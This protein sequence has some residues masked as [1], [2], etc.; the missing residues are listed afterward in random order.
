MPLLP[1][2][3]GKFPSVACL[4]NCFMMATVCAPA[5]DSTSP[6]IAI[7]VEKAVRSNLPIELSD[8][9]QAL[10]NATSHDAQR[11]KAIED[12]L[13]ECLKNYGK[14]LKLTAELIHGGEIPALPESAQAILERD[15]DSHLIELCGA[16]GAEKVKFLTIRFFFFQTGSLGR[17][18]IKLGNDAGRTQVSVGVMPDPYHTATI[19]SDWLPSKFVG[20]PSQ[21]SEKGSK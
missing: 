18:P 8:V 5:S 21:G 17:H 10:S 14:Q 11:V 3:I 20:Q 4:L 6:S 16:V 7:S 12:C 15:L 9:L 2:K 1:N 19:Y 13:T